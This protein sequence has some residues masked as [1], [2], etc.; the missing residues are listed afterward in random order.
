MS[1]SL[2]DRIR[3]DSD[4][5]GIIL[6]SDQKKSKH[7]VDRSF[8]KIRPK[9]RETGGQ[10][11]GIRLFDIDR[12]VFAR[13]SRSWPGFGL[14]DDAA[15]YFFNRRRAQPRFSTWRLRATARAS[16][17]TFLVMVEPAPT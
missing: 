14:A 9:V 15:H 4:I 13:P 1:R 11:E 6:F 2:K 10:C 16:G 7:L 17:D 12:A 8:A 3:F 5:R